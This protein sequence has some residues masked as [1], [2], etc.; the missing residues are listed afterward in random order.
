MSSLTESASRAA[1]LMMSRAPLA[2]GRRRLSAQAQYE[3][4]W[5][6]FQRF[7]AANCNAHRFDRMEQLIIGRRRQIMG[8]PFAPGS[9][10]TTQNFKGVLD[11]LDQLQSLVQA[12]AAEAAM[13]S[14]IRGELN[15]GS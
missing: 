4:T 7:V 10:E 15:N 11:A 8:I 1:L 2:Y 5:R 6:S 3:M 14:V 12:A 13:D 9:M